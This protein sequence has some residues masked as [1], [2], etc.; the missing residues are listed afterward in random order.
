MEDCSRFL[1]WGFG[2]FP[3]AASAGIVDL[4][5]KYEVSNALALN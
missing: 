1:S 4:A 5:L 3:V 2:S